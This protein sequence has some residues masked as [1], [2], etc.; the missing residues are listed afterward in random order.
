M[1][2]GGKRIAAEVATIRQK[3]GAPGG[4]PRLRFDRVVVE[5]IERLRSDLHELIPRGQA[6]MITCTAPIL[7]PGKTAGAIIE[8]VRGRLERR[9]ARMEIDEALFGNQIRASLVTDVPERAPKVIVFVHNPDPQTDIPGVLFHLT[10]S[11]LEA[12][13]AA[14]DGRK[15]KRSMG[16]RWLVLVPEHGQPHVATLRHIVSQLGI[17]A[18]FDRVLLVLAGGGVETLAG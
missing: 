17:A 8:S 9:S 4:R 5:L 11:L 16:D 2:I 1:T 7:Q 3:R 13:D 18:D 10:R 12:V 14:A 15:R 6:V